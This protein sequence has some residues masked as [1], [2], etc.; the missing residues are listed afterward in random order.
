MANFSDILT[1]VTHLVENPF[2]RI[3]LISRPAFSRPE[4]SVNPLMN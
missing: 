1:T 3:E 2:A 4:F